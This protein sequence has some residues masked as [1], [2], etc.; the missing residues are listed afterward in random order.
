MSLSKIVYILRNPVYTGMIGY[1]KSNQVKKGVKT[2]KPIDEWILA[3]GSHE[4]IISKEEWDRV[5]RIKANNVKNPKSR[6]IIQIFE[7]LCWC[8]C[9]NKLYF[10]FTRGKE[11]TLKYYRCAHYGRAA[12]TCGFSIR[13]EAIEPR[14]IQRLSQIINDKTFWKE[15]ER[16]VNSEI[17]TDTKA[18]IKKYE[19]EYNKN[20]KTISNL[21]IHMGQEE[22]MEIAHLIAPQ[23]KKLELRQKELQTLIDEKKAEGDKI[24]S[25]ENT[26]LILTDYIKIWER[27][28][29][30][31][32]RT[33]AKII[34]KKMVITKE[35]IEITLNDDNMPVIIC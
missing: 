23:I 4:A 13:E 30:E 15:V 22:G 26:R 35:R 20:K 6:S 25:L 24:V 34:I 33:A 1:S 14:V 16:Q 3:E 5:Q 12:E 11:R 7:G 8:E 9:G 28:T 10:Y 2:R 17:K 29:R 31:E 32:K 19:S 21:I 27:M 18:D